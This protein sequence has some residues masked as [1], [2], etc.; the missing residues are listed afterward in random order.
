MSFKTA[1][2]NFKIE[3]NVNSKVKIKTKALKD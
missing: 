1:L 2:L 3:L